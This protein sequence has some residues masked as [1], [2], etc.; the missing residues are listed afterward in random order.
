MFTG[1]MSGIYEELYEIA[2]GNKI[3]RTLYCFV[4]LGLNRNETAPTPTI[5]PARVPSLEEEKEA[6]KF[7]I[8]LTTDQVSEWKIKVLQPSNK[9]AYPWS[10]AN[11]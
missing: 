7:S 9:P 11:L 8:P 1:D 5:P 2:C 4:V 10:R 6:V 3:Q